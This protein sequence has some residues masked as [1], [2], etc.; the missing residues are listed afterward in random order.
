MGKMSLE[1]LSPAALDALVQ[2]DWPGNVRQLQSVIRHAL[3]HT[4]GTVLSKECLP[5]VVFE[6]RVNKASEVLPVIAEPVVLGGTIQKHSANNTG[7]IRIGAETSVH[8]DIVS[9]IDDRLAAG[10]NDLYNET[11]EEIERYL[12]ARTLSDTNGNQ[13]KAAE[14][15]GITRGKVRDRIAYFGIQLDRA[16]TIQG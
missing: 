2:Y 6:R 5:T 16:V 3:L 11:M 10:S 9:F 8:P 13:S 14:I 7:N 12:F 4:T 15:L 1:G